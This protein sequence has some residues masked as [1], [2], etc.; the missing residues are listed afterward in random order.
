[1][2]KKKIIILSLIAAAVL[3]LIVSPF[4][5]KWPDGLERVA[6]DKGF[7]AKGEHS[8]LHTPI[9]DYLFPGIKNET[10]A[11]G[12]AGLLGVLLVFGVGY[13]AERLMT[14]RKQA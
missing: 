4:A 11:T 5:S 14:L 3:A 8:V 9:A 13:G 10:V 2:T 12:L 6:D 7:L 1:M